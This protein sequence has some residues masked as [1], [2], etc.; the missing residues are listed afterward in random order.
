MF[1]VQRGPRRFIWES[2]ARFSITDQTITTLKMQ[3]SVSQRRQSTF[4]RHKSTPTTSKIWGLKINYWRYG[5]SG[6]ELSD[7]S[8]VCLKLRFEQFTRW[9]RNEEVR[10]R[11]CTQAFIIYIWIRMAPIP[12]LVT[13]RYKAIF[14]RYS[15]QEQ[16]SQN[17]VNSSK[18][19]GFYMGFDPFSPNLRSAEFPT[20]FLFGG[21]NDL[22]LGR[23]VAM[24]LLG[25]WSGLTLATMVR[26]SSY[27]PGSRMMDDLGQYI[28]Y[29]LLSFESLI[30][31]MS[32]F[33]FL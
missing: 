32:P 18:C 10:L 17:L 9:V 3:E 15:P 16:S 11:I 19:I 30:I 8:R 7:Q 25:L 4:R 6:V 12:Q 28:I 22:S 5:Q 20:N 31:A 33:F 24:I 26:D 29:N 1:I 2:I 13:D 21:S 23:N 14:S 27:Y